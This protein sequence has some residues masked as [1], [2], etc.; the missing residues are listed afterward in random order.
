MSIGKTLKPNNTKAGATENVASTATAMKT[1]A[2]T[3]G[4]FRITTINSIST[5]GPAAN[6]NNVCGS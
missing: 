5:S 6:N 4:N 2:P 3:I 1:H